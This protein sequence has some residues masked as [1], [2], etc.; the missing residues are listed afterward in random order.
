MT[1]ANP[2]PLLKPFPYRSRPAPSGFLIG[3]PRLTP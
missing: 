1:S 3:P 2:H